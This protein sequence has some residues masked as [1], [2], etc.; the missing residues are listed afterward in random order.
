[1]TTPITENLQ[2]NRDSRTDVPKLI[3]SSNCIRLLDVIGQGT[4]AFD[5]HGL[6]YWHNYVIMAIPDYQ[7]D[8]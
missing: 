4:V 8:Q 7:L 6:V 5:L 1:M 2:V 3:I